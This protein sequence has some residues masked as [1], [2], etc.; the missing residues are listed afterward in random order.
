MRYLQ[1]FKG[2][3]RTYFLYILLGIGIF[4]I[5]FLIMVNWIE[6]VRGLLGKPHLG[7]DQQPEAFKYL[8]KLFGYLL[9]IILGILFVR[10]IIMK[11]IIIPV[12]V[13][14]G[15][16]LSYFGLLAYMFGSPVIKDYSNRI[17]FDSLKWQNEELVNSRNPLR[18][19][20]VDDML[21]KHNLV[22]MTKENLIA[23]LGVPPKTD[24]FSSYD[25]VYWL[26]PERGFLSIDSEWLVIKLENGTVVEALVVRD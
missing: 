2:T 11:N 18:I 15:F 6:M 24:Y 22:G 10:G 25:F 5:Y 20:M 14:L 12:S 21:K 13:G 1:L 3:R 8:N 17:P 9:W 26:G 23:L 19:R 4:A 16:L 7:F